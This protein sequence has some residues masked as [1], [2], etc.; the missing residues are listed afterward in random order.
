M[1][2]NDASPT[3][4]RNI[5][6]TRLGDCTRR[7]GR[8]GDGYR[9]LAAAI[10]VQAIQEARFLLPYRDQLHLL[11]PHPQGVQIRRVLGVPEWRAQRIRKALA[12]GDPLA[13]LTA[14]SA[15]TTTLAG[16]LG[17]DWEP[18]DWAARVARVPRCAPAPA[19][20]DLAEPDQEEDQDEP[21]PPDLEAMED[22]DLEELEALIQLDTI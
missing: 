22:P 18:A 2:R 14:G 13:F 1:P 6:E 15:W 20:E 4:E 17:L 10:F 19:E 7:S 9:R 21:P 3:A 11:P 16:L 12:Y 8:A 5:R